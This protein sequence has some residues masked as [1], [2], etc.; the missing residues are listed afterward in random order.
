MGIVMEREEAKDIST[1]ITL[2]MLHE[3]EQTF[4]EKHKHFFQ[5]LIR[6]DQNDQVKKFEHTIKNVVDIAILEHGKISIKERAELEERQKE[7]TRRQFKII[8]GV[9]ID[10]PESLSKFHEDQTYL[11]NQHKNKKR[12][13]E[14]VADQTVKI[15]INWL[16]D[17]LIKVIGW[18]VL[19]GAL[20]VWGIN[21]LAS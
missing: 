3:Y 14:V 4:N 16:K 5:S 21:Q 12:F 11:K 2:T 13:K 15:T 9:D 20:F 17:F 19:V 6:E 10:D 1:S 8:L 18:G 7:H